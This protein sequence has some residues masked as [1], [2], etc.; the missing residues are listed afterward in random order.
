MILFWIMFMLAELKA[1]AFS[2][3]HIYG[4]RTRD[5]SQPDQ[6]LLQ[7]KLKSGEGSSEILT[8]MQLDAWMRGALILLIPVVRGL[9][10]V[11]LTYAGSKFLILQVDQAK[12][13]MKVLCMKFVIQI[14]ELLIKSLL[15]ATAIQ[16][17]KD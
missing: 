9:V 6:H 1:A 5:Q 14:D 15:T 17:L 4:V 16:E 8:I 10:A 3:M 13:V 2:L 11:V 12:I 7:Y